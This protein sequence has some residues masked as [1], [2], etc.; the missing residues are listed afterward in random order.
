MT[1]PQIFC[2]P[3]SSPESSTQDEGNGVVLNEKTSKNNNDEL[4]HF[5]TEPKVPQNEEMNDDLAHEDDRIT[6]SPSSE[7]VNSNRIKTNM[8]SRKIVF[9]YFCESTVSNFPRH[10]SRNH[11]SELE[12]QKI[13]ALPSRSKERKSLLCALRKKGNYLTSNEV[14]KPVRKGADDTNYLPCRYCLGFYSARNLWRHRKNCDANPTKGTSGRNSQTDA[15][16]FLLR[17][18]RVDPQL[19][20]EVFPRMRADQVPLVAKKDPLICAFA[21]R[22][23]KLHR[24]KHCITVTSRKMRE[25]ARL[26]IEAKKI[27]S[28]ITDLFGIL[29]SENYDVLVS[30]TKA[31]SMFDTNKQCYKSPTFALHMG[32][33]LK[34]CCD[35]AL[36][37]ALKKSNLFPTIQTA[38]AEAELKTLMQLIE[39]NWRF[40]VSSQAASDL[41]LQKWNK[42]SLVPLASDLKLL[43]E[44]LLDKAN[45][46]LLKLQ[47][48]FSDQKSYIIL[49]ET[50]YCRLLLLNRRRPGELQRL[51]LETYKSAI[52]NRNSQAY[53]EF[54]EA[55][56]ETEKVLM[57]KFKRIVIRGKR[58]R[59]VPVLISGD[60]QEHLDIILRCRQNIFKSSN[61][62]LFG[63]PMSGE[64]IIGYKVLR[65]YA[66]LCGAKNPDSLTCTRLRKHL[67][68]LTQLFNM[69]ENDMEQ[70]ASFMGHTLGIHR[71]SYRLPDDIYQTARISKLL[72]LMERGEAGQFKGKTLDEIDLN[73]EEDLMVQASDNLEQRENVLVED[74]NNCN[75]ENEVTEEVNINREKHKKR[76]QKRVLIPWTK[77]QKEIVT[78]YFKRHIKESRPPKKGECDDL[79]MKYPEILKNKNWLKIKVF[80]QNTYN[81]K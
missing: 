55:I 77:Q 71:A 25:L 80:I 20:T 68:T 23:L 64:P 66:I 35:I 27:K 29:R 78:T 54:S 62:Y 11:Q 30:A 76:G 9:C 26:L 15:H 34:Q 58:G 41:N 22:Y 33:T 37:Y 60:V 12:V 17:N 5:R 49:L 3:P 63:N 13:L 48:N 53:E 1:S 7:A 38:N 70:L 67:A 56:S 44:Y 4:V 69:T 74:V 36:V 73:L 81:K 10:L 79:I 18:L 43:K 65:K 40:D 61:D 14:G 51:F 28:S 47:Q 50:I 45:A 42:V 31:A 59:G 2:T 8:I 21:A 6:E 46:A 75:D 16:N 57:N 39:G 24:E 52:L 19:R 72:I 32:T